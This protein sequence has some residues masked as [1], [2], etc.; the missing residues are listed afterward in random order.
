MNTALST[1]P[2][3]T[4]PT[5]NLSLESQTVAGAERHHVNFLS[6][7][8]SLFNHDWLSDFQIRIYNVTLP[9]HQ[10]VICLQSPYLEKILKVASAAAGARRL[11]FQ[12][13]SG[14]AYWRVFEYM[15]TNDYSEARSTEN[16]EE[17]PELLRDIRVYALAAKFE[18]GNLKSL[19]LERFQQ[20][21]KN[22]WESNLF[23]ECIKEV[24]TSIC[25]SEMRSAV[26]QI[27]A[28]HVHDLATEARFKAII[29]EGGDFVCDY[30]EM[31]YEL[32]T[33]SF[34]RD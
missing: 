18:I 21:C 8:A 28:A 20:K 30:F 12:D 22:R 6:S 7:T 23:A 16:L 32:P 4:V 31:L 9:V 25:G 11:D 3:Q 15:Y 27:A 14:I 2:A 24:Y 17:D 33:Y 26:V 34:W 19:A 5:A 1:V 10:L 13:G 29:H